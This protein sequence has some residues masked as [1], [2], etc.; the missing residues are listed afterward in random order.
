MAS[1][2]KKAKTNTAP[3]ANTTPKADTAPKPD[4]PAKADTAA[5][6]DAAEKAETPAAEDASKPKAEEPAAA[7]P[8]NYSRGEGRETGHRGLPGKLE[9]NF[10]EEAEE[11]EQAIIGVTVP[12]VGWVERSETHQRTRGKETMGFVSLYPSYALTPSLR[13]RIAPKTQ[14]I[15]NPQVGIN[16]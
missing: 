4:T 7:A 9:R 3:K 14:R 8:A 11:E 15:D 10:C 6:S 13:Y 2:N 12:C 5:K 1:D 16:P